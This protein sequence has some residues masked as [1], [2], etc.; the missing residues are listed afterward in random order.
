LQKFLDDPECGKFIN[1]MLTSLPNDVWKT[2]KYGGSLMD[3]FNRTGSSMGVVF[4]V[5]TR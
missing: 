5:V 2:S 4:G 3:N 1:A